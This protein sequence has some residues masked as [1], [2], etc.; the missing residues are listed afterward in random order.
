M[1]IQYRVC[2]MFNWTED[3]DEYWA[4]ASGFSLHKDLAA[5]KYGWLTREQGPNTP[6]CGVFGGTESADTLNTWVGSQESLVLMKLSLIMTPSMKSY[7]DILSIEHGPIS[8][9]VCLL[10]HQS[11]D[12]DTVCLAL[13]HLIKE[14]AVLVTICFGSTRVLLSSYSM[15]LRSGACRGLEPKSLKTSCPTQSSVC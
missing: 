6:G 3:A 4:I 11:T 2:I 12:F 5:R 8:F 15:K 7:S 9:F 10:P 1:F 13:G 14:E